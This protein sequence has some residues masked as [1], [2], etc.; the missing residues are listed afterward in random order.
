MKNSIDDFRDC[1]K[2]ENEIQLLTSPFC[3]DVKK[4]PDNPQTELI[5]LQCDRGIKE[6]SLL[7]RVPILF[8]LLRN[9]K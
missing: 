1:K 6:S 3:F 5:N 8:G 2:V 4:A 7:R 9:S